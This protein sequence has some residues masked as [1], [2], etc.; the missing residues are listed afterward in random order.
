MITLYLHQKNGW[1]S[2]RFLLALSLV[3]S[4]ALSLGACVTPAPIIT[5]TTNLANL[6]QQHLN[7]LAQIKQFSLKGRIG[8]NTNGK[9]YSAGLTWL[10][11][12]SSNA[13]NIALFSPFG[14]KL[15]DIVK[16]NTEVVLT[17]AN[18]N[19]F[20]AMDAETLTQ[21]TLGWRLPLAGLSDWVLGR[22][23]V[24][25]PQ[26][27]NHSAPTIILDSLGRI[28]TLKQNGWDITY[29]GYGDHTGYTLPNKILLRSVNV[30]LKLVVEN[31]DGLT[32][33][34]NSTEKNST[35]KTSPKP[36][37]P[38]KLAP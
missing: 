13:D 10:H 11:N 5:S 18:G 6:S 32:S 24:G 28:A 26:D 27:D 17:L 29:E 34:H 8:I 19:Q 35:E 22:V 16:N 33:D 20:S 25:P 4:L 31:W 14:G 37:A 9:G 1:Q 23:T 30:N 15:S 12:S 7:K 21:N 3:L 36:L 2:C 38:E